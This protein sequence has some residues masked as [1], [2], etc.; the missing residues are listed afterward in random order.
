VVEAVDGHDALAK[1]SELRPDLIFLDLHMPGRDGFSVC[2]ELRK[3]AGFASVPIVAMTAGLMNG[4][5]EK[6]LAS[7][8]SEFLSKPV[9]IAFLRERVAVLL[10]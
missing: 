6:A 4:E 5:C 2:Q 3:I 10:A 8:F 7:G 1:A 9:R